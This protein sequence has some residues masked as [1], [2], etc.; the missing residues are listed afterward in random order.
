MIKRSIR[1]ALACFI[2]SVTWPYTSRVK[3]AVWWPKFSCLFG[4]IDYRGTLTQRQRNRLVT[5]LAV[6]AEDRGTDATGIAYNS[7]GRLH[8]YK[9]PVPA[10]K[11]RFAVPADASVIMGHTRMATQ[12]SAKKQRNNHPF[13]GS[14][15]D[16]RFALAHNGVIYNDRTL[17]RTFSLPDTKI[18]TDSYI[19]VQLL[20]TKQAL[21]FSSLRFAAEQ[22]MGSFTLTVLDGLYFVRGDNPIHYPRRGVYVYAS[23]EGIL[24][25]AMRQIG[26]LAETPAEVSLCCGDILKID[27]KGGIVKEH[28]DDASLGY[29][30]RFNPWH[31]TGMGS[32]ADEIYLDE[33]KAVAAS[34]GYAHESIDRLL[35]QGFLPEEIEE[36]LYECAGVM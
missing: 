27:A 24:E 16:K 23:T 19:A 9:R 36:F 5:T 14:C 31:Y 33:L 30:T 10:H 2:C 1:S 35:R 3:A 25:H 4:I 12:G 29:G 22:L 20:E 32:M 13:P 8:I 15:G 11:V 7:G 17:R 34:F 21:D 28:F 18:E 6:T 26:F